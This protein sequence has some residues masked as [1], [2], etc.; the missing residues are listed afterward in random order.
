MRN[1]IRRS[2]REILVLLGDRALDGDRADEPVDGARELGE[3]RVAGGIGDAAAVLGDQRVDDRAARGK[4]AQCPVLVG[5]HQ[6]AVLGDVGGENRRQTTLDMPRHQ[7]DFAAARGAMDSDRPE[8]ATDL[9][10]PDS[11]PAAAGAG[12][13]APRHAPGCEIARRRRARA[14]EIRKRT[15]RQDNLATHDQTFPIAAGAVYSLRATNAKDTA[16]TEFA[17]DHVHLRSPDPEETARYYQRMFGAEIIKSVQSD[18]RERVDMK[19]GGVMMFIAKVEPDQ[20]L[21]AKPGGSYVGLD[22]L[23][24]RVRISMPSVTN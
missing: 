14:P 15:A 10:L 1:S 19:L 6:P 11:P 7:D 3:Q 16:M 13:T 20:R 23:G 12:E 5:A 4:P 17:Y 18:G 9:P 8:L 21:A 22:H 24:L 2:G